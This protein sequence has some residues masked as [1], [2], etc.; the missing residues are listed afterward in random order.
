VAGKGDR[1]VNTVQTLC[2]HVCKCKNDT[3]RNCSTNWGRVIKQSG[4]E[5]EFK[6]DIF[7]TL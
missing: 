7:D 2:T 3:C 5:D 6:Y 1:R 4:R